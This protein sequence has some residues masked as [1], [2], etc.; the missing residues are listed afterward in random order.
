MVKISKNGGQIYEI[1]NFLLLS[2][3]N[4]GQNRKHRHHSSSIGYSRAYRGPRLS[5]LSINRPIFVQNE[6]ECGQNQ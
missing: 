5:L 1:V 6:V 4:N 2:G 3:K